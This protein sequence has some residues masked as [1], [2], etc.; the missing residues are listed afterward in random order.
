MKL[1]KDC[2]F[3][4]GGGQYSMCQRTIKIRLSPV[5]GY[6]YFKDYW[7]CDLS[8]KCSFLEVF[9]FKTCGKSGKYWE[10]K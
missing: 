6:I 8:R 7:D 1:C 10:P 2:K 9:L 4:D 5:T 3:Y